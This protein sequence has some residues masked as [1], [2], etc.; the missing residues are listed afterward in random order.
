MAK[1]KTSEI[2]ISTTKGEQAEGKRGLILSITV[3]DKFLDLPDTLSIHGLY[4]ALNEYLSRGVSELIK[5]YSLGAESQLA[6]MK[7]S[8]LSQ[9]E[10]S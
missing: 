8:V 4:P 7:N 5:D 1:K 9:S 3:P 6:K 2:E 10:N